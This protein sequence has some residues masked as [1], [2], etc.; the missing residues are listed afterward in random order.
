MI[1]VPIRDL[2]NAGCHALQS[3]GRETGS[4]FLWG[5]V[6]EKATAFEDAMENLRA[7]LIKVPVQH[8][9]DLL[10][11]SSLDLQQSL[12]TTHACISIA[13][14]HLSRKRFP[15]SSLSSRAV[16]HLWPT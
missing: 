13:C 2:L 4:G 14:R 12:P 5:T 16:G 9:G 1:E 3:A 15:L 8:I 10:D 7:Y 6:P 11:G